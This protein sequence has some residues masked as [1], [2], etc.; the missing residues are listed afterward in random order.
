MGD[1]LRYISRL[2]HGVPR[3]SHSLNHSSSVVPYSDSGLNMPSCETIQRK[4]SVCP[5]IQSAMKPP[6]LAPSAHSLVL[7]RKGNFVSA[8]SSPRIR[9]MY[10]RPPQSPFTPSTNPCPYPVEPRGFTITTA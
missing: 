5:R 7:S 2:V 8:V 10:G 1:H 3:N 9:S 4:R 6:K